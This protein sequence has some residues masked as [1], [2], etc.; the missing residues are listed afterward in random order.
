[1]SEKRDGAPTSPAGA[2]SVDEDHTPRVVFDEREKFEIMQ[3]AKRECSHRD[4]PVPRVPF[5][6]DHLTPGQ[7]IP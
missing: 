7:I 3:D 4:H 1:M 6:D 5:V 2:S